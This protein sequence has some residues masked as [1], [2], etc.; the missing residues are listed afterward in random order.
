[1]DIDT[2]QWPLVVTFRNSMARKGRPKGKGAAGK[3]NA[4]D[5]EDQGKG[6][7]GKSKGKVGLDS[8]DGQMFVLGWPES[9]YERDRKEGVRFVQKVACEVYGGNAQTLWSQFVV[10]LRDKGR[11]LLQSEYHKVELRAYIYLAR[12]LSEGARRVPPGGGEGGEAGSDEFFV[13]GDAEGTAQ[14]EAEVDFVGFCGA[15]C[16]EPLAASRGA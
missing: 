15:R 5:G 14:G 2:G 12:R 3:G 7:R 8:P 9:A 13:G 6:A 1:M 4:K 10:A 11:I 16:S